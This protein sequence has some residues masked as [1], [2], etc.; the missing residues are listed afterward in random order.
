MLHANSLIASSTSPS[1]HARRAE[2]KATHGGEKCQNVEMCG[3]GMLQSWSVA[4]SLRHAVVAS[5]KEAWKHFSASTSRSTPPTTSWSGA[6]WLLKP[7]TEENQS[8][9]RKRAIV[10]YLVVFSSGLFGVSREDS[11]YCVWGQSRTNGNSR[12]PRKDGS[13]RCCQ[14]NRGLH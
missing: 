13:R 1:V 2:E 7:P 3:V 10:S 6:A 8:T 4:G 12:Y 14:K 9:T 5:G 11:R